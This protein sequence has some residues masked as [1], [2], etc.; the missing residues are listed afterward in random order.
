[1]VTRRNKHA[2]GRGCS[3]QS[4]RRDRAGA[5]LLVCLFVVMVTAA[6]VIGIWDRQT[7]QM[8]AL[9]NTIRYEKALY[10]AGAAVHHALAELEADADWRTGVG[11]VEYPVGSG[12]TYQATVV[13]N[14]PNEVLITGTGTASGYTRTLEVTVEL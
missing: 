7:Y 13:D 5:A 10:L 3:L 11:P 14:G 1:M 8:S 12:D 2:P 9:R 6:L 4:A